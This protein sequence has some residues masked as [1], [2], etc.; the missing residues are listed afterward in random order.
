MLELS[1]LSPNQTMCAV[2]FDQ[3]L[4]DGRNKQHGSSFVLLL[5][6]GLHIQQDA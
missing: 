1:G 6:A 5:L 4:E 2:Y 3:R